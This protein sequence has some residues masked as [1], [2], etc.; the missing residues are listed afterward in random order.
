MIGIR[1]IAKKPI[2][3]ATASSKDVVNGK[4]YFLITGSLTI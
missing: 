2:T 4:I 3:D 1:G